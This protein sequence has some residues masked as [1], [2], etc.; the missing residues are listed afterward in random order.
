MKNNYREPEK[1]CSNC[2]LCELITEYQDV[3]YY[4]N[5]DLTE[6]P[7][8]G[9]PWMQETFDDIHPE[10]SHLRPK[11]KRELKELKE[12]NKAW[13]EWAKDREVSSYGTCDDCEIKE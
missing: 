13:N 8:S 1:R 10:F 7:P 11:E 3:L 2:K 9:E 6:R 12:F 5:S 4:C